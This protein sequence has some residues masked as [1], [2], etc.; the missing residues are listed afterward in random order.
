MSS[1]SATTPGTGPAAEPPAPAAEA[2]APADPFAPAAADPFAPGAFTEPPAPPRT[3]AERKRLW[4]VGAAALLAVVTGAA[5]AVAVTLPERTDLPG[6]ATPNDGRYAFPELALPPLPVGASAPA[7]SKIRTHAADLRALLLPLPKGAT[8]TGP[9]AA[10]A[11]PNPSASPSPS[12]TATGTATG[13]GTPTGSPSASAAAAL[14]PVTGRW[15]P[16]DQ[17]AMLAKDGTY[18]LRLTTAACRAA[19]AQ[20]WTAKDGTRTELRLFRFG[21]Q[22]DASDFYSRATLMT[23][24]KDIDGSK[25]NTNGEFPIA[26][27][28]LEVRNATALAGDVPT[29]RFAWLQSGDV[30]AL[31]QLTNPKGVPVQSFRQVVALQ[32][33][34]LA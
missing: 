1:D 28:Q 32:S 34:L 26:S 13:T 30:V 3:P 22:Y 5:T 24:T 16:C 21:S 8:A 9:A 25:P 31:V 17:D 23:S 11:S 10:A 19:A 6:L 15:V 20:G 4:Q 12:A 14:P 29:G 7:E 27:G 33:E 2:P 18:S